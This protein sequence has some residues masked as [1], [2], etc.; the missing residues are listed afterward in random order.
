VSDKDVLV[1]RLRRSIKRRIARHY[2]SN[3]GR[4][5]VT[6]HR[7]PVLRLF[8]RSYRVERR[9]RKAIDAVCRGY[10]REAHWKFFESVLKEPNVKSVLILGV[11]HGR[12]IAYMSSILDELGRND[13]DVVGVDKFEDS[14]CADWPEHLHS[15]SWIEAGFGAPPELSQ[16][17]RNLQQL[18]HGNRVR[19]VRGL[20]EEFLTSTRESFDLIYIDTSHDYDTT[21]RTIE[22]AFDRLTEN[23]FVAGDDFSDDGTWGVASAVRDCFSRFELFDGWIWLA[24]GSARRPPG[25]T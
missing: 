14:A 5:V 11:Y 21:R 7:L 20:A 4:A 9:R 1:T 12:D 19:L 6:H 24:R 23:G 16:A 22:L 25:R 17:L 10:S 2:S 8:T 15:A 13:V 3:D 18:G